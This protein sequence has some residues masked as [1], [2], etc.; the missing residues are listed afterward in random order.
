MTH[1]PSPIPQTPYFASSPED[2]SAQ[3]YQAWLN[4]PKRAPSRTSP[5]TQYEF[6]MSTGDESATAAKQKLKTVRSHVMKNYLQQ[7]QQRQGRKVDPEKDAS[8]ERRKGKQRVR[9]NTSRSRGSSAACSPSGSEGGHSGISDVRSLFSDFA[10][11][12][13]FGE[14]NTPEYF[15]AGKSIRD[16]LEGSISPR[17]ERFDHA[18]CLFVNR[19][20]S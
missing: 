20:S 19:S 3:L 13:P 5:R 2:D 9:S 4:P 15:T 14:S 17:L 10:L 11:A 1:S 6:I 12:S 7:Q 16:Q 8:R 18:G